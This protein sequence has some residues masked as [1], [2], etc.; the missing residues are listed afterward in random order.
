MPFLAVIR[1]P[2][3]RSHG[4][5]QARHHHRTLQFTVNAHSPPPN[6]TT[7]CN[8][9][10]P[11]I[12]IPARY[13]DLGSRGDASVPGRPGPYHPDLRRGKVRSYMHLNRTRVYPQ[14]LRPLLS[15][16]RRCSERPAP[17]RLLTSPTRFC[18]FFFAAPPPP[19]P[20]ECF[21][22]NELMTLLTTNHRAA[23]SAAGHRTMQPLRQ[24]R[25]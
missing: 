9:H 7:H 18:L 3:L 24:R 22:L 23:M 21:A 15:G 11:H 5:A 12:T 13:V 10:S 4:S 20:L 1:S 2:C 17:P 16:M 8:V 14:A 25:S 19:P 6:A